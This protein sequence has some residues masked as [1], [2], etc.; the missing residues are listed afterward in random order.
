MKIDVEGFG[1][2]VLQGAKE[3]LNNPSLKVIN[4]ETVSDE[5]SALLYDEGFR[6]YAYDYRDRK[7]TALPQKILGGHWDNRLYVR[8]MSFVEDRLKTA[9]KVSVLG[10]KY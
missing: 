3:L 9:S 10:I 7:L 4:I 5:V 8:D 6:L 2:K 1:L